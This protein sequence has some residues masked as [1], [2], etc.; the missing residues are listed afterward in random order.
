L[1]WLADGCTV[2]V[3]A[4]FWVLEAGDRAKERP[5]RAWR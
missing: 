5:Y 4:I 2:L 3:V 1:S